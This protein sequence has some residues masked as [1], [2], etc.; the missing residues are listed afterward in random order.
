MGVDVE[1]AV[2]GNV[3]V[4]VDAGCKK[5]ETINQTI[6]HLKGHTRSNEFN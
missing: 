2:V 1:V 5:S 3:V 4:D 6:S